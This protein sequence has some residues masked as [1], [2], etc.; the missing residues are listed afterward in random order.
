M[1]EFKGFIE[2]TRLVGVI[3]LKLVV[4]YTQVY[5]ESDYWKHDGKTLNITDEEIKQL[6]KSATQIEG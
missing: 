5:K 1:S 4:H 6:I 2:V 3:E